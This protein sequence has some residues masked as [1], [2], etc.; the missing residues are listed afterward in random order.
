MIYVNILSFGLKIT[1][2]MKKEK[3]KNMKIA[4]NNLQ[5]CK[6]FSLNFYLEILMNIFKTL[7]NC[8]LKSW[9]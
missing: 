3:E 9:V 2:K 1:T 7:V 5:V 4:S 8:I 6:Y